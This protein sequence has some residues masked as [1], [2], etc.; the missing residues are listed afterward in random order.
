LK[1]DVRFGSEA[2]I[3]TFSRDVRFTPKADIRQR[4]LLMAELSKFKPS[5]A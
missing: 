4:E 5:S 1:S 2:D 3:C